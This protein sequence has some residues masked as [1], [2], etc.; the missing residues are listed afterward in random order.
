MAFYSEM[1][2]R[3]NQRVGEINSSVGQAPELIE[4]KFKPEADWL[5]CLQWLVF[6]H[7][8][9]YNYRAYV[10]RKVGR[11][12]GGRKTF[13]E[14]PDALEARDGEKAELKWHTR[15]DWE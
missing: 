8:Y 7:H 10:E 13:H 5:E 9:N 1:G 15:C 14:N 11:E 12:V 6:S 2:N 4:A 3:K